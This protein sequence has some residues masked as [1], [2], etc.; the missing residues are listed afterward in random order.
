M[1][2]IQLPPIAGFW[3]RAIAF[4]IDN[5][6]VS[7]IALG[8]LFAAPDF[9]AQ[10]YYPGYFCGYLLLV[11]YFYFWERPAMNG[12]TPGKRLLK[13]WLVNAEGASPSAQ[14]VLLRSAVFSLPISLNK[15]SIPS[16]ESWVL[17]PVTVILFGGLLSLAYL[18][19]FNR[20]DRRGWHDW[21]AGTYV[22]RQ[23]LEKES[24][25]PTPVLHK[26]VTTVIFAAALIWPLA[27]PKVAENSSLG[28]LLA[29]HNTLNED[30]RFRSVVVNLP[31]SIKIGGEPLPASLSVSIEL[32]G[33]GCGDAVCDREGISG[34][35]AEE[36]YL[37]YPQICTLAGLTVIVVESKRFGFVGSRDHKY[38][39]FTSPELGCGAVEGSEP[40]Q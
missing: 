30:V 8:I 27:M 7:L 1:D 18:M 34:E 28:E 14:K 5:I 2:S 32:S 4:F 24:V 38:F 20:T 37:H 19:I 16:F 10:H 36:V 39:N 22:V 9:W 11:G 21:L 12:Q 17:V 15:F 23:V 6:L 26:A 35:V 40:L 13:I 3:R 29:L 25:L 31:T 33:N